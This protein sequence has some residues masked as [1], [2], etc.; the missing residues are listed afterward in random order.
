[1]LTEKV[2]VNEKSFP[3]LVFA[4]TRHDE[5]Q[6]KR[7]NSTLKI[8]LKSLGTINRLKIFVN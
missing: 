5:Q 4:S 1:M 6:K 7:I 2:S 3:L 8:K